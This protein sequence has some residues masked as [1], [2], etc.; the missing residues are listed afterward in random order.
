MKKIKGRVPFILAAAIIPHAGGAQ[1]ALPEEY[2]T[3]W[4]VPPG[5]PVELETAGFAKLLC[6]VLFI[7]GR[8]LAAAIEQAGSSGK[9]PRGRRAAHAAK[10]D[11]M[12]RSVSLTLPNGVT[13][14][15]REFADQG[16]V[17]L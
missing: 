10:V 3:R 16:C 13:R 14:S 11:W 1:A 5:D 17:I 8:S 4:E 7:T 2:P 9:P 6:S 15:A 12:V